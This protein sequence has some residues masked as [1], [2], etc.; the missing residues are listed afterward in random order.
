MHITSQPALAARL[1]RQALAL[2]RTLNDQQLLFEAAYWVLT[3]TAPPDLEA[4]KRRLA[5]EFTMRSRSGVRTQTIQQLLRASS[6]VLLAWGERERAE[7]L[8]GE[9]AEVAE[10]TGYA[11]G[12]LATLGTQALWQVLDGD[13][14]GAVRTADD[15]VARSEELGYPALGRY[16]SRIAALR[17]LLQLGRGEEAL[18]RHGLV[19]ESSNAPE[20]V[21]ARYA[22]ALILAHLGRG[23][24]A[25]GLLTT[26]LPELAADQDEDHRPVLLWLAYGLE[27]ALLLGDREAVALL[28]PQLAGLEHLAMAYVYPI[29]IGRLLGEAAAWQGNRQQ[30]RW[31]YGQ[32]LA[33]ARK[34]RHRPEIALILLGLAELEAAEGHTE[35]AKEHLSFCIPELEAMQMRPGLAQARALQERLDA[36]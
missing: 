14:A 4:E 5:E 20:P 33:V 13:L 9:F 15:I 3:S 27:T 36:E 6:Q 25:G 17:P 28:A 16:V 26:V 1:R 22:R 2:A 31:C 7:G 18:A 8:A 29:C 12:L 10:R 21:Y 23:E 11:D 34:V 35:E 24:E 32:A 19:F 30:A